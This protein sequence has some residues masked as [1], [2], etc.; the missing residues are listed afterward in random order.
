Y[1]RMFS[2]GSNFKS[3]NI[4]IDAPSDAKASFKA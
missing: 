1:S 3:L 2:Q 4:A